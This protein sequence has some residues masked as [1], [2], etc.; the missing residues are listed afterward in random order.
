MV[1]RDAFW[2]VLMAVALG[3][4]LVPRLREQARFQWVMAPRHLD[5]GSQRR[6]EPPHPDPIMEWANSYRA[7]SAQYVQERHPGDPAMLLAAGLLTPDRAVS[8]GLLKRAA[9]LKPDP[10][11][12]SAYVDGMLEQGPYYETPATQGA[13][14][15]RA[16]EMAAARRAIAERGIPAAISKKDAAPLLSALSRWRGADPR[17]AL[18]LA[19]E[20]WCLYGLG[21]RDEA[22]ARWEQASRLPDVNAYVVER[23]A[24]MR[25]LLVRMGLPAPEA[26]VASE[27]V[28]RLPSLSALGMCARIAYHEGRRAQLQGRDEDAIGCWHATVSVG[29]KIQSCADVI[30]EFVFGADVEGLGA[31]PAWRWYPD[32]ATGARGRGILQGRFYF[33]P[34]HEFHQAQVGKEKDT[35]L[36]DALVASKTRTM[37][38]QRYSEMVEAPQWYTRAGELLV[39]G[40]LAAGFLIVAGLMLGLAARVGPRAGASAPILKSPWLLL[41][42]LPAL[43]VLAVAA[44]LTVAFSRECAASP[45]R[46]P[47]AQDMLL[48]VA[49]SA[50]TALALPVIPALFARRHGLACASAWL[51]SLRAG[52]P[53]AILVAAVVYLGLGLGAMDLRARWLRQRLHPMSEMDRGRRFSGSRW[54]DPPVRPR[55][56]VEGYPFER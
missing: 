8:L 36:R 35:K 12:L 39:F 25:A 43:L 41:T 30:S 40:Q 6:K 33:G 31:A 1:K 3:V 53:V 54:Q 55:S 15:Q 10:V 16:G 27:S 38:L 42:S 49:L 7:R 28:L 17:N 34:Q 23:T 47:R 46:A 48:G 18:P 13:D 9:E 2:A 37:M 52:L 26:V 14:P 21:R 29:R 22:I 50:V 4:A 5:P 11:S 45:L 44:G 51:G 56:W 24:P 20:V 19:V 32:S